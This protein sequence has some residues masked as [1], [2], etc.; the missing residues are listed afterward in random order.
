MTTAGG[1]WTLVGKVNNAN[2]GGVSEPGGWFGTAIN[3]SNLASPE[4]TL[5]E[6]P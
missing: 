2:G 1:G 3:A 6:S 4:L 5:N